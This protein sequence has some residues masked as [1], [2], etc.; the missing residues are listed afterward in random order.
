MSEA[1]IEF[2]SQG[3]QTVFTKGKTS[4]N[5]YMDTGSG[6][7]KRVSGSGGAP[8]VQLVDANGT[9]NKVISNKIRVS[10]TPYYVDITEGNVTGNKRIMIFGHNSNV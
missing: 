9:P 2:S 10:S 6:Q 5:K 1:V 4:F 3:T 8:Y 7:W